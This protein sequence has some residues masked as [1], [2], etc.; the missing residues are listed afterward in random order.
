MF[1]CKHRRL[2]VEK[3]VHSVSV[4]LKWQGRAGYNE[5]RV[6]NHFI[7]WKHSVLRA[8]GPARWSARGQTVYPR[9]V[10][11]F[12]VTGTWAHILLSPSS[13]LCDFEVTGPL[14]AFVSILPNTCLIGFGWVQTH[15]CKLTCLPESLSEC[16][17]SLP[18]SVHLCRVTVA[19][20]WTG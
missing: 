20:V 19:A 1:Q 17:S 3:Q 9:A 14:R 8:C 13:C 2:T 6:E 16:L 11:H 12:V 7:R 5:T 4:V 15:S 18:H 10:A